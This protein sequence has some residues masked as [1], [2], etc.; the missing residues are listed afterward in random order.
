MRSI[1]FRLTDR[2][3]PPNKQTYT[4]ALVN[5]RAIIP[6]FAPLLY[7]CVYSTARVDPS[8]HTHPTYLL[9]LSYLPHP[10]PEPPPNSFMPDDA[11]RRHYARTLVGH[12]FDGRVAPGKEE[13]HRHPL[14][15]A[16]LCVCVPVCVCL[17]ACV[18]V[19]ARALGLLLWLC[20]IFVGTNIGPPEV[21]VV[22]FPLTPTPTCPQPHTDAPPPPPPRPQP[23]QHTYRPYQ[24]PTTAD[25]TTAIPHQQHQQ[26]KLH[27]HQPPSRPRPPAPAP[28]PAPDSACSPLYGVPLPEPPPGVIPTAHNAK[29]FTGLLLPAAMGPGETSYRRSSSVG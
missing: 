28:A 13:R 14:V 29:V 2:P 17:C 5:E 25:T 6:E 9:I 4:V 8:H 15:R 10:P 12:Q 22:S 11:D 18:C 26:Q 23:Q 19:C 20:L 1:L 7:V 24:P 16:C 27:H 3:Y 21:L